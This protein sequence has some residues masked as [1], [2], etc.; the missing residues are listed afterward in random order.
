MSFSYHEKETVR[1][2]GLGKHTASFSMKIRSLRGTYPQIVPFFL[3]LTGRFPFP[4]K[5]SPYC[6]IDSPSPLYYPLFTAQK[7]K[8]DN[9][10]NWPQCL[11][12]RHERFQGEPA[13]PPSSEL[14]KSQVQI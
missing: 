4:V 6:P 3:N 13:A 7:H 14:W 8:Q 12:K 11:Q 1:M 10:K 2:S 5:L 9:R